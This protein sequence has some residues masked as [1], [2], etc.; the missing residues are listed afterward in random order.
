MIPNSEEYKIAMSAVRERIAIA[1]RHRTHRGFIDYYG[2]I[3]VCNELIAIL[4]DA[5]KAA[6]CGDYAYAYSVAALILIHCSKLAG[7]ADDSAGGITDTIHEVKD[8]LNMTCAGVEYGSAEAEFIYLQSLKDSQN[9][10]FDGWDEFAYDLLLPT[11]R[12]ANKENVNKLYAVLDEYNVKLSQKEYSSWHLE[13]DS[14]VRLAAIKAVDGDQ[15]AEAFI[16]DHIQ[17]DEIRKIAYRNALD[18]GDLTQAEK[19]CID[20]INSVDRPYHWTEKWYGMLFDVYLKMGDKAKQTKLAQDLLINKKDTSYYSI[21]K[22]LLIEQSMWHQAY[23]PLL[24]RLS[25]SLPYDL[26]MSILSKE[27]ETEKLMG[28]LREHPTMVF[29]YGKQLS[30][31]FPPEVFAICLSLIRSKA[32]ESSYRKMYKDVCGNIRKL[33]DFGGESEAESI[34]EELRAK[35]PRRPAMID[36]LDNLAVKLSKK[37]KK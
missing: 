18:C 29:Q 37:R 33:F 35:Y 24:A 22:N 5:R 17:Y 7:T 30:I 12:L 28:E 31:D 11:A 6:E 19:L 25:K 23:Q 16:N 34:I 32:A 9:K 21:L 4:G 8:V 14:L 10:A 2:C 27:G 15:A 36:E 13:S 20:K 3:S 26:Y 1:K